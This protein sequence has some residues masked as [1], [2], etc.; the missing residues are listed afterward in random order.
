MQSCSSIENILH[1]EV[2]SGLFVV[3]VIFIVLVF[4]IVSF[5]SLSLS[6]PMVG[7]LESL[8]LQSC[9]LRVFLKKRKNTGFSILSS[10]SEEGAGYLRTNDSFSHF[11]SSAPPPGL[12]WSS[13][14][15]LYPMEV[16]SINFVL[17][18]ILKYR[19]AIWSPS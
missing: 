4:F 19:F 9:S 16:Y 12:Q 2:F 11:K 3:I 5:F 13:L 15:W 8:H 10:L 14:Y 7:Q 17:C 6:L 18:V 1:F